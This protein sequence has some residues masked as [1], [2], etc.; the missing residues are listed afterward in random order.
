MFRLQGNRTR[1]HLLTVLVSLLIL[2]AAVIASR[3]PSEQA[4]IGAVDPATM[5]MDY[6]PGGY[7]PEGFPLHGKVRLLTPPVVEMGRRTRIRVEYTV[8]DDMPVETGMSLEFWKHF[9]SDVEEFQATNPDAPAYFGAEFT[10]PGIQSRPTTYTNWV[11]RNRVSVFPYRKVGAVTIEKGRLGPGE[12]VIFD[13]GGPRGVRMQHYAENLFNFRFVITKEDKVLGYAGDACLKVTGGPLRRLRVQAPS[14]VK[15]GQPFPV[16]IVPQDEWVSLAKDHKGLSF[17]IVS[18]EVQGGAFQY[19]AEL[20]HYVA[21]D[22][23][24]VSEGVTRIGLQTADGRFKA[25]SNPIWVER[26]PV[27]H[28]YYGDLHQHTYLHD[29][30]GVFEELYLYARRVGLLD[31]GSVS[32]HHMPMSV[33]GPRFYLEGKSFPSENWPALKKATKRMNGWQGFV[34]ILGYEYSVRTNVG[35]HHNIYYNA[36]DAKSTMQLDPKEPA[37]PIAK[38]LRTLRLVQKPTLVIPHIGGGPPDW[39]HPTDPRIE[40]LFEIASV[41]GVFEESFQKHLQSGLRLAA[42]ASGDTHTVSMGNAYPGI[43]YVMT[44]P[45][46]G[47]YSKGKSRDEI[48][49]GLYERRTFAVTGNTR[50]LMDFRVNGEPMGGEL[51]SGVTKEAKLTARISGT[52]PLVRVD[53]LKNS[54]V[55]HTVHPSRNRGRLLR[56]IWGDNFYQRR[57]AAGL[58]SGELRPESGK[59]RLERTIHLDQAFEQVRQEGDR[60]TW[61]T[62]AISNDRDGFLADISEVTG[63]A[64]HFRLDDS[65]TMGLFEVRIPLEQLKRDGYFAWSHPGKEPHSYMRKMGVEPAFFVECELVNPDGPMDLDLSYDD[66]KPLKPGDYWYLRAEQL[67]TNKAWSSPVWVN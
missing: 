20:Q 46:T 64:L 66:R 55:I 48:W 40:R 7:F 37:A 21:R 60:I 13:L 32:P 42:S 43:N 10:T 44:N 4:T 34:S 52:T 61:K 35:G 51:P 67:D 15:L 63:D 54:R 28:V 5:R 49:N 9:T 58:R 17:R 12:K 26:D 1:L 29:G 50:I 39:S 22:V 24:A 14:I 38:M 57:A 11:Q 19:D 3:S 16:E 65:D 53:L 36:D 59:L 23:K 30:R 27:R 2:C 45:L 25:M 62:A 6:R 47:V 56:V 18:G 8:G 33:T 41:H 31:F